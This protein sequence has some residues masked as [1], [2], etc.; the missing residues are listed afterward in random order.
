M[1]AQLAKSLVEKKAVLLAVLLAV[2]LAASL[3]ASMDA[4][5]ELWSA[6]YLVVLMVLIA[7]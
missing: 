3:A 1:V 5:S 6:G 2:V 7:L 4:L